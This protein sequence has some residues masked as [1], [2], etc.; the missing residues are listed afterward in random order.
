[1]SKNLAPVPLVPSVIAL[2]VA[3]TVGATSTARRIADGAPAAFGIPLDDAGWVTAGS[4]LPD[5]AC[6][7]SWGK[8]W[9]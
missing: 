1:V 3:A 5:V 2:G 7:V 6:G 9:S 8:R 4:L